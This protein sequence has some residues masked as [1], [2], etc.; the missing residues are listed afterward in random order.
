MKSLAYSGIFEDFPDIKFI[1]HH[2]GG[3]VPFFERRIQTLLGGPSVNLRKFYND[4]AVYG[5]APALMC[6][7]AF[8]GAGHLVF[9]QIG[10]WVAACSGAYG[11]NNTFSGRDGYTPS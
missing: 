8:C 11:R 7:Y 3:T 5:S 4:T 1:T 2:C 9:G 10:H 6:G